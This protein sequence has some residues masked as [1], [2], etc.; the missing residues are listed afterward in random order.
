MIGDRVGEEIGQ[1]TGR[2]VLPERHGMPTVEI[3]FQQSG[4]MY[5]VHVNDIG[6]YESMRLPDGT[7]VGKGRGVLMTPDGETV[8]YE[9]GGKGRFVSGGNISWRG[10][11]Y[12]RTDSVRLARLNEIVGLFEFEVDEAGKT[13][14]ALWEWT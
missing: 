6:T 10:A 7:L 13:T 1:V 2:R 3:A 14:G 12:Y 11:L 8:S 5:G 9:G 4:E